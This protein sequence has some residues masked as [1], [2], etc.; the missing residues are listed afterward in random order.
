MISRWFESG[1]TIH[2][3]T[4]STSTDS[5]GA[6]EVWSTGDAVSGRFRP[7]AGDRRLSADKFTEFADAK[8]YC[9]HG[10]SIA[11]GDQLRKGSDSYEVV[12]VQNPMDMDRFLQV[13]LRKL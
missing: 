3:L 13:E 11:V 12:F 4:T 2:T 6:V 1:W 8:F 9:A 7:L 5:W 10:T